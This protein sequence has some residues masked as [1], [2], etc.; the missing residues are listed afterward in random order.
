MR[1]TRTGRRRGFRAPAV[2]GARRRTLE[3]HAA[4]GASQ[5]GSLRR[6]KTTSSALARFESRKDRPSREHCVTEQNAFSIAVLDAA[7][8]ALDY[9]ATMETPPLPPDIQL[10]SH[11]RRWIR[12]LPDKGLF[13]ASMDHSPSEQLTGDTWHTTV[14]VLSPGPE[15][16]EQLA[17]RIAHHANP[18]TGNL[19]KWSGSNTHYRRRFRQALLQ[20]F[21]RF[22]V[23]VLAVSA[24]EAAIAASEVHFVTELG[25]S[26]VYHCNSVG[27]K[28][29]V[30]IG[31][32]TS[33]RNG[34][35]RTLR[36][37]THQA[38]G[39]LF[40][41]HFVR[42]MHLRMFE[43]LQEP[44]MPAHMLNWS[45]YADKPPGGS[46]GEFNTAMG[47]IL[48]NFP[49][50]GR[51]Q[52]GYFLEGDVVETDL[53]A[54]NLAGLLNN[55]ITRGRFDSLAFAPTPPGLGDFYWEHWQ[56]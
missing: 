27:G 8:R 19:R 53:L 41:C 42:R 4:A 28:E 6:M 37:P 55:T 38:K 10:V 44:E 51:I 39:L 48:G 24:L 25:L 13:F 43:A 23:L 47:I 9:S 18:L 30:E 3:R 5:A 34:R 54:D 50:L 52:W 29:F 12:P 1:V 21:G 46:G 2:H 14:L 22:P 11:I 32:F 33:I 45:F 35:H 31:P 49:G 15:H 7:D 40:V 26:A 36:L 56:E 16:S 17:K 20:E